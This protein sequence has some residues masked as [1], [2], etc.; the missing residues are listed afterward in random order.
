MSLLDN[1][2]WNAL[3]GPHARFA[4]GTGN[5]RRYARGFSPMLG[6]ADPQ[7]P[8]FAALTPFCDV[9]EHFY[10]ADWTGD[11]PEGWRLEAQASMYRMV[12]TLP[13]PPTDEEVDCVALGPEHAQQAFDLATLTKPGPFGPKTIELGEYFGVFEGARMVAMAGERMHAPG[14]REVSG[15]CTHPDYQ[16]RG[17]ARKLMAKL[18]RRQLQRGET[19]FLHVMTTNQGPHALYLRM[20]FVNHR[21]GAVRVVSRNG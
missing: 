10:C 20:G 14:L 4:S 6:F 1:I 11:V 3:V 21:Q 15:V 19:P 16:G 7:Q 8:D 17:M 18:V 9:G 2:V 12:W 5:A 13:A